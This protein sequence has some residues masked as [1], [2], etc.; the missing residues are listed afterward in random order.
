V[1]VINSPRL[2][3]AAF[4]LAASKCRRWTERSLRVAHSLLVEGR[5][6]SEVATQAEMSGQQA[7]VIRVRFLEKVR[8]V[9]IKQ[10]KEQEV[11]A[12][13]LASFAADVKTL[14]DEGY[15]PQQIVGY[16]RQN[17]VITTASKVRE[18]LRGSRK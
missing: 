16:L 1:V 18:Q 7:N 9:R 8:L 11:P 12:A 15:T 17:G 10:F 14:A 5:P 13:T 4:E 3:A 6:L 2:D